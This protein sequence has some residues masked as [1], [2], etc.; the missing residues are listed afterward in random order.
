MAPT[1]IPS[2]SARA[3][4]KSA[5][6]WDITPDFAWRM[7][8]GR[9]VLVALVAVVALLLFQQ[10]DPTFELVDD[11]AVASWQPV[12]TDFTRQLRSGHMPVWSHHTQCGYPLLGWPQPTF[13]YPVHWLAHAVCLLAGWES[14]EMFV[15]TLL[16]YFLAAGVA[17]IYLRRF[18]VVVPAAVTA[19][20]AYTFSGTLLGLGAAWPTYVF[21]AAY[22]PIVMLAL[23]ELRA[24]KS[25][26]V[27]GSVSW[28][29]RRHG[30]PLCRLDGGGQVCPVCG[31][32]FLAGANPLTFWTNLKQV[33]IAASLAL[34]I[35]MAQFLPSAEII[36]GSFRMG[37]GGI[38][39]YCATPPLWL[40]LIFPYWILPWENGS[41]RRR[42]IFRGAVRSAWSLVRRA[43]LPG[44]ARTASD[45]SHH[46][47][48]LPVSG[49]GTNG[50][51]IR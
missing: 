37:K 33:A 16:H 43:F 2:A 49:S 32:L 31:N 28:V 25:G 15:S 41:L 42:R 22:W 35:G 36:V 14:A 11:D 44:F 12:F 48:C 46:G 40:G 29:A 23:E 39:E 10:F 45:P 9:A 34:V 8:I 30:L 20:Y 51:P 50:I 19:A 7:E 21:A 18:G 5:P 47:G 13:V 3:D 27:L 17:F 6:R 1:G 38:G 26:A 24:G 4:W